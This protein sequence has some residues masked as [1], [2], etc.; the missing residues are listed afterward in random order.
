MLKKKGNR[1]ENKDMSERYKFQKGHRDFVTKEGRR[2]QAEKMRGIKMPPRSGEHK[3]KL[4]ENHRGFLGKH[5][6]KESKKKIGDAFRGK[7]GNPCS[8]ITRKKISEAQ[9]GKWIKENNPNWKGGITPIS[10]KIRSL[11]EYKLWHKSCIQRDFFTC[12][13]CNQSGGKLEVHHINNFAEFPEIRF[14][15]DNGIALCKKCHKEFHKI[16]GRKNNTR[17]QLEKFILKVDKS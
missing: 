11:I 12:Q 13:K 15:I 4:V 8:E 1:K 14:A 9:K 7:R 3:R 16:Y 5:H 6:T 17:E 2:R 10:H